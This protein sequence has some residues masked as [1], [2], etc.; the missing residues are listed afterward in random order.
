MGDMFED[1]IALGSGI[2][3]LAYIVHMFVTDRY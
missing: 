2:A 3:T 1:L